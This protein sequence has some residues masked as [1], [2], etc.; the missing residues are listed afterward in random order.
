MV[1]V[2]QAFAGRFFPDTS[3][4]GKRFGPGLESVASG[5]YEIIGVVSDAKYRS[6][7]EPIVPT[8]FT[9]ETDFD[10]F[11][12]NVCTR[13]RPEAVIEPVR[14]TLA[15]LDPGLPFL[16]VHTLAEEVDRSM[17]GERIT[18]SLASLFGGIAA[19][20]VGVG[21]YGLLAYVVT[22]RRRE[23]GIRMALGAQSVDVLELIA[24]QTLAMTAAGIMLGLGAALVAG[25]G[26][27][28]LLYGVSPQDPKSLAAATMFVVVVA[29]LAT[30]FPAIR[31][32]RV[33]PT[34]A[35]RYE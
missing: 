12:L 26:I 1:V 23:I 14:K 25:P 19:L 20:L 16:E 5:K 29:T 32:T 3:P 9:L 6:L 11:V 10:Q 13:M 2:N 24:G 34:V 22:Q 33:D 15:S 4:V 17:A 21:I 31:A 30:I 35:L 7:R 18:A 28:S 27:R 8:F